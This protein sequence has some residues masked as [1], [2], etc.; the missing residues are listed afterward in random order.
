MGG[1]AGIAADEVHQV[2]SADFTACDSLAHAREVGVEAAVEADLEFDTGAGDRGQRAIDARQRVIDRFFA[3]DVLAGLRGFH[4]EFGMGVG[5]GADQHRVDRRIGEDLGGGG[6]DPWN[7]EARRGVTRRLR[8][9]V[10]DDGGIGLRQTVGQG[11][12]V[13]LADA[14][15]ADDSYIDGFHCCVKLCSMLRRYSRL[16]RAL[17]FGEPMPG[18]TSCSTRV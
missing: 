7:A 9:D 14:A 10:C 17:S 13:H 6:G 12:R 3:E 1:G 2:R 4:N 5:G 15:G 11:L 16:R 18:R 8:I